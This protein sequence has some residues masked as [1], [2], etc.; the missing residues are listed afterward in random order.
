MGK[1]VVIFKKIVNAIINTNQ[2]NQQ[3]TKYP[4]V[5][6][7][8][9][10]K[11]SVNNDGEAERNMP[12]QDYLEI[13]R[14]LK[15][16]VVGTKTGGGRGQRFLH[17]FE[18]L[19]RL[20]IEEA[21]WA[22]RHVNNHTTILSTSEKIAIPLAA[23][24]AAKRYHIPHV[25]IAHRLSS[26]FKQSLFRL[27]PLHRSFSQVVCI[28]RAQANYAVKEMGLPETAVTFIHDKVDHKFFF[29][30]PKATNDYILAVGQERRDYRT[31]LKAVTGTELK[32]IIVASSLWSNY[33][34]LNNSKLPENV[35]IMRH[36]PY[37]HLRELYANA[38]LVV[39]PL[40]DVPYA[41]GVN[42]TLESMAMGKPHIVTRTAGICD[43][44]VDN[45]TGVYTP[46]ENP[47]VLR[48]QILSLWHNNAD[49]CR[50]GTNARQAI[51]D[52]MNL[53]TYSQH[54]AQLVLEAGTS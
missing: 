46:P 47:Q 14:L 16:N 32:L 19:A 22:S 25:V 41:A 42:A 53:D 45:E 27:W 29:P 51:D 5:L 20:N 33:C 26:R 49:I 31:L 44:V 37:L 40:F 28:S 6:V 43:Y 23:L 52:G 21:Y 24:L 2:Q 18:K 4:L 13:A 34:G 17:R 15:G 9:P 48:Q 35:T 38:R 12:R 30:M 7:S 36:I 39:T 8:N 3:A 10:I 50:L 11:E 1:C 54:I